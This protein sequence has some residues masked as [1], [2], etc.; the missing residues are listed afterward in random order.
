MRFIHIYALLG[1]FLLASYSTN[2][3]GGEIVSQE[4][5]AKI[6]TLN[7]EGINLGNNIDEIKSEMASRDYIIGTD[8]LSRSMYFIQF[9]KNIE[10][11]TNNVSVRFRAIRGKGVDKYPYFIEYFHKYNPPMVQTYW[12]DSNKGAAASRVL[13]K[14]CGDNAGAKFCADKDVK[15]NRLLV[16]I[17]QTRS[18]IDNKL[19]SLEI[20]VMAG[21]YKLS[22]NQSDP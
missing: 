22:A 15:K 21:L 19:Y 6:K 1:L 18:D 4:I 12:V 11:V 17:P 10:G 14:L 5:I 9:T 20:D 7:I 2:A 3:M 16:K 13:N 8:R